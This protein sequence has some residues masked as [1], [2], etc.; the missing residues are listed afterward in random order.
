[1]VY[2][3]P[4]MKSISSFSLSKEPLALSRVSNR[5]LVTEPDLAGTEYEGSNNLRGKKKRKKKET[6]LD[7]EQH[8]SIKAILVY[9]D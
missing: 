2:T 5:Y 8:T 1:M 3:L 4:L 9:L 7:F 6:V